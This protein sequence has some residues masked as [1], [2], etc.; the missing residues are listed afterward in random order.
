MLTHF[1]PMFHFYIPWKRQ[2]TKP[3]SGGIKRINSKSLPV[4]INSFLLHT[5]LFSDASNHI[6]STASVKY[7]KLGRK[8][9][10]ME[11]LFIKLAHRRPV[12]LL[13]KVSV[14]DYEF[15]I[16]KAVP[17]GYV[18]LRNLERFYQRVYW[19]FFLKLLLCITKITG[20]KQYTNILKPQLQQKNMP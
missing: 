17:K 9:P 5:S 12:I 10:L 2:R 14:A 6:C 20:K 15:L 4:I 16:L 3:F 8:T 18:C 1:S 11:R 19:Q 7:S 13:N